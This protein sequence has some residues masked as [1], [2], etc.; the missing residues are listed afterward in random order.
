MLNLPVSYVDTCLTDCSDESKTPMRRG[1]LRNLDERQ[2]GK[3]Q[4]VDTTLPV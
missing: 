3:S 2:Q 4:A 1:R